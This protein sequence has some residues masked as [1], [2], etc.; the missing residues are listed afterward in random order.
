MNQY[1]IDLW[2][3]DYTEISV[4]AVRDVQRNESGVRMPKLITYPLIPPFGAG[5][6]DYILQPL[7]KT[8]R[9]VFA[10]SNSSN[11]S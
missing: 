4:H 6:V 7:V 11:D 3:M 10:L 1:A 9:D 2:S 8:R 5:F